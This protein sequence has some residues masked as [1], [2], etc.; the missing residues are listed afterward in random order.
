MNIAHIEMDKFDNATLR[1][2]CADDILQCMVL[3]LESTE[4]VSGQIAADSIRGALILIRDAQQS[5][6]TM[7]PGASA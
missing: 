3:L 7:E 6:T 1:L 4:E 5:L 2:S